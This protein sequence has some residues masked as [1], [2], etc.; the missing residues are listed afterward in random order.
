LPDESPKLGTR[1]I[2]GLADLPPGVTDDGPSVARMPAATTAVLV[3][4]PTV[5]TFAGI[6]FNGID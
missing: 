2:D 1:L 5:V 6:R 4:T 3:A